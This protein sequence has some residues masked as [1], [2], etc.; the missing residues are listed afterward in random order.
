MGRPMTARRP[1]QGRRWRD[2]AARVRARAARGEPCHVCGYPIDL[3]LPPRSPM[4]FS[5]D[6]LQELALGGAE[7][8]PQNLRPAHLRHNIQRSLWLTHQ[9]ARTTRAR[10]DLPLW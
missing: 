10:S 4:S 9:P 8:D 5:V 7:T 3:T 2:A 1:R 6:H